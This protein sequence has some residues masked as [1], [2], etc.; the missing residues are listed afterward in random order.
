MPVPSIPGDTIRESKAHHVFQKT[1]RA[2]R[3]LVGEVML[4]DF[5]VYQDVLALNPNEG[6]GAG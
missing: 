2:E 6:P 4:R 1:D 5:F 3:L